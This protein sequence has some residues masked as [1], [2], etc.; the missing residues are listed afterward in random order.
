MLEKNLKSVQLY[1]NH[2]IITHS[3]LT[4]IGQELDPRTPVTS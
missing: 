3:E 2:I 4:N 1:Q